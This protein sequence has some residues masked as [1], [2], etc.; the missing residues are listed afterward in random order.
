MTVFQRSKS[1]PR[2]AALSAA[3]TLFGILGA[4]PA[5]SAQDGTAAEATGNGGAGEVVAQIDGKPLTMADLEEIAAPQLKQLEAQ[6]QKILEGALGRL[7]EQKLLE[8]EAAKRGVSADELLAAEVD[9]KVGEVTDEEVD[10]WYEENQ[11]R[12]RQPKEQVADQIKNF[13]QQRQ[14]GE[15][16]SE[17]L[18]SLRKAHEVKILLE[19]PREKIAVGDAPTKGPED[20]PV[21]IVEFSDFE[22]PFCSRVNPTLAQVEENYGEK[23]RIAFK[24]FPLA[25]HPHAEKAAQAALCAHDQGKFW[26]MHDAMFGNQQEL[27]VEQLKAKAADL[28][29]D[30]ETFNQCL[31]SGKH[32]ER[33]QSDMAEGQAAGVTGTPAMFI[34]GR[35]VSGAVPYD[36]I[37]SVIDDELQR[38]GGE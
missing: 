13:L 18:A 11:A 26:E 12:V 17:F 19:P 38:K 8:A 29:L 21:T 15:V 37:S 1:R 6:R 27:A 4:L 10:A 2:V 32:A 24:Q 3:L 34:N 7:V 33:V 31:D 20:A 14:A 28:G 30:A 22:C 25:M 9:S 16:R 5:C 35:L 23:V 36:Q